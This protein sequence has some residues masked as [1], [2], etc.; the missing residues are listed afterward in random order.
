[1][2]ISDCVVGANVKGEKIS[3]TTKTAQCA[4]EGRAACLQH[5]AAISSGRV[6][7]AYDRLL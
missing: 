7:S 4:G 3:V 2:L 5:I 6:Y 1:M